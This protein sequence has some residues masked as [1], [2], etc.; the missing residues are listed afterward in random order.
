[1]VNQDAARRQAFSLGFNAFGP[2]LG[3]PKLP[4]L[5]LL[6][7]PAVAGLPDGTFESTLGFQD[8]VLREKVE[9]SGPASRVTSA[10]GNVLDSER[11]ARSAAGALVLLLGGA[12]LRRWLGAAPPA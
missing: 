8:Q 9:S 11:L 3:I 10:V 6:Q 5:P 4:P 7:A 12:H 1:M 2:N